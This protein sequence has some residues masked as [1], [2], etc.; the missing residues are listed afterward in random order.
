MSSSQKEEGQKGQKTG[1]ERNAQ[2][3]IGSDS[4]ESLHGK[5][6]KGAGV[7]DAHRARAKDKLG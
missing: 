5:A 4:I 6:R 7:A 3:I 2:M 1:R